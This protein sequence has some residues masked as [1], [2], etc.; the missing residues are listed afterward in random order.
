M[1]V[2]AFKSASSSIKGD[3]VA[4][5]TRFA[6]FSFQKLGSKTT[7]KRQVWVWRGESLDPEG[8]GWV[9]AEVEDSLDDVISVR[10]QS[11]E[12]LV[13]AVDSTDDEES[14]G[15]ELDTVVSIAV[16][17]VLDR[18]IYDKE[19]CDLVQLVHL[20]DPA[21]LRALFLRFRAKSIYTWC[22]PILLALNPF[23]KLPLYNHE[24][25]QSYKSE[26]SEPHV[27]AV[28]SNAYKL[29]RDSSGAD[30]SNCDQSILISGESGAGKTESTKIVMQ[31]LA[32]VAGSV[33]DSTLHVS[34]YLGGAP[35]SNIEEESEHYS[36]EQRVLESN[37]ILESFGNARTVRND[38]SSRFGKFI[39]MHFDEKGNLI[40]ASISTYLLEKVRIIHQH[41]EERGYHVFFQMIY[42][43]S[44]EEKQS[45]FIDEST[46]PLDFYF[47][48]NGC[49]DRRDGVL[50][51]GQLAVTKRAMRIMGIEDSDSVFSIIAAVL[52]LGNLKFVT[53]AD[54][55]SQVDLENIESCKSIKALESLL[56]IS[57]D[58]IIHA[59]C[60]RKV[61]AGG[62][63]FV[64]Q[65][66]AEDAAD[67]RDALAKSLYSRA[68]DWLVRRINECINQTAKAK[69]FIAVLDIFGFEIFDV[70]SFEQLCINYANERLQQQFNDFVFKHEQ[71]IYTKEKISWSFIDFP[72]NSETVALIDDPKAMGILS[73]L[74]DECRLPKGTDE[75]FFNKV[76]AVCYDM[77][78]FSCSKSQKARLE[79]V[80]EHYAG[81]VVYTTKGFCDKN[82]DALRQEVVDLM[83]VSKLQFVS[84]LFNVH[85]SLDR[86]SA[87]ALASVGA[88]FKKQLGDLIAT[89]G[90]T[91]PHYIRCIKPNDKN[92]AKLFNKPR[93]V[94][95]LRCGGV[96]EA[97]RVARAGFPIRMPHKI[98]LER[99]GCLVGASA[100]R[101]LFN[102]TIPKNP[103]QIQILSKLSLDRKVARS[104]CKEMM[105]ILTRESIQDITQVGT[106]K[107]FLRKHAHDVLE[108]W[109]TQWTKHASRVIYQLLVTNV[110]RKVYLRTKLG[111]IK[112]QT[113]ARGRL[114]RLSF[115]RMVEKRASIVLQ[116]WIR[117]SMFKAAFHV[118]RNS[119]KVIQK[120][121]R[122]RR[123]RAEM[124]KLKVVQARLKLQ[125]WF[126]GAPRRRQFIVKLKAAVALQQ[127]MRR[128]KARL[129]F[130]ELKRTAKDFFHVA[131]ERDAL[132][133]QVSQLKEA[134]QGIPN[135]KAGFTDAVRRKSILLC[136]TAM[137]TVK[138]L[139]CLSQIQNAFKQHPVLIKTEETESNGLIAENWYTDLF[140]D[141]LQLLQNAQ[142]ENINLIDSPKETPFQGNFEEEKLQ[143]EEELKRKRQSVETKRQSIESS[144]LKIPDIGSSEYIV[145][146]E[147]ELEECKL[148]LGQAVNAKAF[149][150]IKQGEVQMKLLLFQKKQ[151]EYETTIEDLHK[152]RDALAIELSDL[153]HDRNA[154]EQANKSAAVMQ[155]EQ[156]L[157]SSQKEC[158]QKHVSLQQ[159]VEE[160]NK[161]RLEA[162]D[163]Q[164][165]LGLKTTALHDF[166]ESS[167]QRES[168]IKRA[169]SKS[170]GQAKARVLIDRRS[171]R[172]AHNVFSTWTSQVRM[173]T[174]V[175]DKL[176]IVFMRLS[177]PSPPTVLKS[178]ALWS[179][180]SK[181]K[182][183]MESREV[184]FKKRRSL[185]HMRIIFDSWLSVVEGRFHVDCIDSFFQKKNKL[186]EL[187]HHFHVWRQHVHLAI[188]EQHWIT[189]V[190]RLQ[191]I[192]WFRRRFKAWKDHTKRTYLLRSIL[193]N[194]RILKNK[195]LLCKIFQSWL[196]CQ[197]KENEDQLAISNDSEDLKLVANLMRRVEEQDQKIS[198]FERRE[199]QNKE[200]LLQMTPGDVF[201][202][203]SSTNVFG[204]SGMEIHTIDSSDDEDSFHTPIAKRERKTLTFHTP[205]ASSREVFRNSKDNEVV[206]LTEPISPS[207][208]PSPS[209]MAF[210]SLMLHDTNELGIEDIGHSIQASIETILRTAAA[211]GT[212]PLILAAQHGF[213]EAL[214]KLLKDG[215]DPN[216]RDTHK[217][218]TPLHEAIHSYNW[219]HDGSLV[220]VQHLLEHKANVHDVNIEGNTPLMEVALKGDDALPIARE[221]VKHGA[222]NSGDSGA[223]TYGQTPLHAA[224]RKNAPT[225]VHFLLEHGADPQASDNQGQTSLHHAARLCNLKMMEILLGFQSCHREIPT[226]VNSRDT[227]GNSAL[228]LV[229]S[230]TSPE[231]SRAIFI[232]LEHDLKPNLKNN[233]GQSPLHLL[234][235]NKHATLSALEKFNSPKVKFELQDLQGNTAL[236]LACHMNSRKI[237]A[238]L[239][240]VGAQLYILNKQ[241]ETPLNLVP[242]GF[243][244]EL[245]LAIVRPPEEKLMKQY[246]RTVSQC[247]ICSKQF[248]M[249]R[250]TH[251][252]RHCGRLCCSSC[253]GKKFPILKF[254]IENAVTMC[255]HCYGALTIPAIAPPE[256]T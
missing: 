220:M 68:F 151:E 183:I 96:L 246:N 71:S 74:D 235:S 193:H 49:V 110:H 196:H 255:N 4:H 41:G 156:E 145:A 123:G 184:S 128:V 45:W 132:R 106:T 137:V 91:A 102:D 236:H 113:C 208:F 80:I 143:I 46:Q 56:G 189:H 79:F 218:K 139:S 10:L 9:P 43:G 50:D 55:Q 135:W 216:I 119:I 213:N 35:T 1:F 152:E 60:N 138:L 83:I 248:S 134:S 84:S 229:C 112:I 109:L 136:S 239:V 188:E 24:M 95:Q 223:N 140:D 86:R 243:A 92:R 227:N 187:T 131:A 37:P 90:K 180:I 241:G 20:H 182:T 224:V 18:N 94:D 225:I 150:D 160:K 181:T 155:L 14:V 205:N 232:L 23:E 8:V 144:E 117:G 70:N 105:N 163:V 59:L 242:Q 27:Y 22:G 58:D 199:A 31:Y 36:I 149:S 124:M 203:R 158:S 48:A 54:D 173:K 32:T 142:K 190:S 62:E 167:K 47:L 153:R 249:F 64:V 250:D 194:V 44:K 17:D 234:C 99:Y 61:N 25:L 77:K 72:S 240:K 97:V 69:R 197:K 30:F 226:D 89:I 104:L 26:N 157:V 121:E 82:R 85:N 186:R 237:A 107:V 254:K 195:V 209:K 185:K 15:S 231:M 114:A 256:D 5:F 252:C 34:D 244:V 6:I 176:K 63:E 207:S 122:G 111:T 238:Y 73:I 159:A 217:G 210:P 148:A 53:L 98:F 219:Q 133:L 166:M 39:Q 116:S 171:R 16:K 127:M 245:L 198:M 170:V 146:I 40:G 75:G 201:T 2:I 81:Q 120:M 191:R 78:R 88:D 87:L 172:V 162:D 141:E 11:W 192:S 179:T 118:I 51:A 169:F 253:A 67:T 12:D 177:D 251:S 129:V 52:H 212:P 206:S 165:Q 247:M 38:N 230:S 21:I 228:H 154:D 7:M 214:L 57:Q 101:A 221:L 33:S 93:V 174:K 211:V 19:P 222:L 100:N 126:R 76:F 204:G 28:A 108:K 233:A 178:F 115:R 65:L 175:R 130:L 29:M 215:A 147:N 202:R 3:G 161:A 200:L 125:C 42:G 168:G 13:G 66:S 164:R 103:F